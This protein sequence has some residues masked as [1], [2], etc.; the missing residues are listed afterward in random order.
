MQYVDCVGLQCPFPILKVKQH[1]PTGQIA[2]I[3]TDPHAE[4]DFKV[5]AEQLGY[6]IKIECVTLITLEKTNE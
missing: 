5:L 1:L 4:I 2:V 6:T 3:T